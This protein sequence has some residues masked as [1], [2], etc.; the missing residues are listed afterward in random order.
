MEI[1][2]LSYTGS[3]GHR[4][5]NAIHLCMYMYAAVMKIK[6]V[7][8]TYSIYTPECKVFSI[9]LNKSLLYM[10]VCVLTCHFLL[11]KNKLQ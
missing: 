2:L 4:L 1:T 7:L 10:Y 6:C 11:I 3:A 9:I 8:L 5:M